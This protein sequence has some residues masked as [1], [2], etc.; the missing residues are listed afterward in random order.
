MGASPV[1]E[2]LP[3]VPPRA[4]RRRPWIA[5]VLTFFLS[6]LGQVYAGRARRG[7]LIFILSMTASAA[8]LLGWMRHPSFRFMALGFVVAASVKIGLMVDAAWVAR[9]APAPFSL[10]A[11]NRWYIYVA[12]LLL[13]DFFVFPQFKHT[14]ID[15]GFEAFRLPAGVASMEPSWMAGDYIMVAPVRWPPTRGQVVVYRMRYATL[16]KRVVALPGDTV[17]MSHGQLSVNGVN[18]AEPYAR[19]GDASTPDA[20]PTDS[21]DFYWQNRYLLA[22]VNAASYRPTL[23]TWGPLVLPDSEY[24][25]LGDNRD[26]GMDSRRGGFVP[27]RAILARPLFIYWSWDAANRSVRWDRFGLTPR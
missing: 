19:V 26:A 18:V 2:V 15:N 11:Y 25:V 7:A 6:G 10:K 22:G 24:F 20:F 9:A 14:L 3:N 13:A 23:K 21:T 27:A 12:A 4:R 1:V 5:S 17:A 8:F 16:L